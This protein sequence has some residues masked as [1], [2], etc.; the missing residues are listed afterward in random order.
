MPRGPSRTS[1]FAS[2]SPRHWRFLSVWSFAA[3]RP[4]RTSAFLGRALFSL[5]AFF[6]ALGLTNLNK[7]LAS[8]CRRP[9][10]PSGAFCLPSGWGQAAPLI[11]GCG[12]GWPLPVVALPWPILVYGR[13]PDVL[14]FWKSDY[15]SRS[16][17]DAADEPPWYLPD[18]SPL[19]ARPVDVARPGGHVVD[20]PAAGAENACAD[21]GSSPSGRLCR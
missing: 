17:A 8:A 14:D 6:L 9:C 20:A 7:G 4:N 1:S 11:A 10:C 18:Q 3:A 19:D 12:A 21:G 16:V 2:S 13:Y 15:F 5:L